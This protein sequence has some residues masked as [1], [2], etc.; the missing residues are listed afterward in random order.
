MPERCPSLEVGTD[1]TTTCSAL[2]HVHKLWKGVLR[3]LV[4]DNHYQNYVHKGYKKPE[5]PVCVYCCTNEPRPNDNICE[6]C[7]RDYAS[8]ENPMNE[9]TRLNRV[10][11]CIN[12]DTVQGCLTYSEPNH[13]LCAFCIKWFSETSPVHVA[14]VGINPTVRNPNVIKTLDL[15]GHPKVRI[16]TIPEGERPCGLTINCPGRMRPSVRSI[17]GRISLWWDCEECGV[18]QLAGA[19]KAT[20]DPRVAVESSEAS[21]EVAI[22]DEDGGQSTEACNMDCN[23]V[24]LEAHVRP[25]AR[26]CDEVES[27]P[28]GVDMADMASHL[29][30]M[31]AED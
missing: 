28:L 22:T 7:Y 16:R 26:L 29:R 1:G 30:E 24:E 4:C 8:D 23:T 12:R 3:V 11:Y 25:N 31:L 27:T 15:K 14:P 18:G 19:A 2:P 17:G 13:L 20:V 9:I 10:G 21:N 6:G 5:K